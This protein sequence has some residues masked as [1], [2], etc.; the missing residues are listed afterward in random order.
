VTLLHVFVIHPAV[1]GFPKLLCRGFSMPMKASLL[2][3]FVRKSSTTQIFFILLLQ[4]DN[5]LPMSEM[6]DLI[7]TNRLLYLDVASMVVS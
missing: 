3:T 5:E 7:L 1:E 6:P 2:R 4:S